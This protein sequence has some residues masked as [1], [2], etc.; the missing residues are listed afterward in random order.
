MILY[1]TLGS[2]DL[3]RSKTFY[4]A[5]L[6]PL[7]ATIVHDDDHALG[8]RAGAGPSAGLMLMK[9]H[10][11]APASHGNGVMVA[12]AADSPD[13]VDDIYDAAMA[14]ELATCEGEPGERDCVPG[15]YAAYFRDPDGNKL[16]ALYF[17]P[18]PA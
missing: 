18:G 1:T 3:A 15:L 16:G 2:S 5:V 17:G 9:P 13:Q 14:T 10:N 4:D 12:L 7:G 6:T 11:G 8:Y